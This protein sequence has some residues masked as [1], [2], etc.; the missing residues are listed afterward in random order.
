MYILT[1]T[2]K[3]IIKAVGN[4]NGYLILTT[5]NNNTTQGR[6]W[7]HSTPSGTPSG[8]YLVMVDGN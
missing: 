1:Y 7:N 5:I 3:N 6:L 2:N 8:M 4:Q